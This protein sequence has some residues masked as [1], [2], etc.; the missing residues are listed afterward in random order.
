MLIDA[1]LLISVQLP[2]IV[3]VLCGHDRGLELIHG[4]SVGMFQV[5]HDGSQAVE[6][7]ALIFLQTVWL[8]HRHPARLYACPT[9]WGRL[10]TPT[11]VAASQQTNQHLYTLARA[12]MLSEEVCRI[13][14]TED[15]AKIDSAATDSLLDPQQ[16][17]VF[18]AKL[19][20][21]LARTNT[22]RGGRVSPHADRH[23]LPKVL[24]ETLESEA[25]AGSSDDSAE[26]GF[27]AAEGHAGLCAAP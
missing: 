15:F 3:K 14:L 26:L 11:G 10:S 25:H 22:Y 17:R 20:E 4:S 27:A 2:L 6:V 7:M 1:I 18:V 23:V 5:W 9:Q 13:L 8:S 16:M 19:A 24:H 21:T 12:E